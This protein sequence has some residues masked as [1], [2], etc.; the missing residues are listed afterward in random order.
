MIRD[1]TNNLMGFRISAGWLLRILAAVIFGAP[2][3]AM[4]LPDF[5]ADTV[6][7]TN[8]KVSRGRIYHTANKGS[9]RHNVALAGHDGATRP[10][11]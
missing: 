7:T 3:L 5:S 1:C 6:N 8:G 11:Q 9:P 10:G 4:Q 2:V